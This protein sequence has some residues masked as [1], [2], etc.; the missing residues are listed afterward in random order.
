V[1]GRV[2]KLVIDIN[3]SFLQKLLLDDIKQKYDLHSNKATRSFD[4]VIVILFFFFPSR[5][6]YKKLQRAPKISKLIT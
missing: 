3:T 4:G 2:D 6:T 1:L 5:Q